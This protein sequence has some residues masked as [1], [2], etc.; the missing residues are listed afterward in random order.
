MGHTH[1]WNHRS[2][3]WDG[4]PQPV[5]HARSTLSLL[6]HVGG[7]APAAPTF[8]FLGRDSDQASGHSPEHFSVAAAG[9]VCSQGSESNNV[10]YLFAVPY[11]FWLT[12]KVTGAT[13]GA[14]SQAPSGG[15]SHLPLA[16]QITTMVLVL[17]TC[18]SHKR[19]HVSLRPSL[20]LAHTRGAQPSIVHTRNAQATIAQA[21]AFSPPIACTR[22]TLP[23]ER[24]HTR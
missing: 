23:S 19:H 15:R 5:H 8:T 6:A 3:Q 18:R 24:P 20:P 21:T 9:Q 14:H 22:G 10:W 4:L 13:G 11:V 1:I 2:L 12:L 16:S 17:D 7:S